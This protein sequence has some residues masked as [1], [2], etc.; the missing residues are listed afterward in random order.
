MIHNEDR[1]LAEFETHESYWSQVGYIN[2][3]NTILNK[4]L[5]MDYRKWENVIWKGKPQE[6]LNMIGFVENHDR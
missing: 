5:Q 1:G 2:A 6:E 4:L 3:M